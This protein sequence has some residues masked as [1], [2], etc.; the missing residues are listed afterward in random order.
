MEEF[1]YKHK[2][3]LKHYDDNN[4]EEVVKKN[5]IDIPVYYINL[6]RCVDRRK[7]IEKQ[8][9]DFDIKTLKRIRAVDGS[10][11]RTKKKGTVSDS[12]KNLF[13][14]VNKCEDKTFRKN[15]I[16]CTLSH[17]MA[18]KDIIDG[19]DKHVLVIE[20]DMHF[21]LSKGW[22][23]SLTE[24]LK[25]HENENI[26][27]LKINNHLCNV[28]KKE[29]EYDL[30]EEVSAKKPYNSKNETNYCWST[31]A[32]IYSL[33]SAKKLWDRCY[34]AKT[35][36]IIIEQI[37]NVKPVADAFIFE[38]VDKVVSVSPSLI[39]PYK[40]GGYDSNINDIDWQITNSNIP[41]IDI[42]LDTIKKTN[43][44]DRE[45]IKK[46]HII[47]FEFSEKSK[48]LW[49]KLERYRNSCSEVYKD[50]E[51]KVWDE[52]TCD[53]LV[54]DNF[55]EYYKVYKNYENP[56]ERVDASRY[57]IQYLEGGM[58]IDTDIFCFKSIEELIRD[59]TIAI[60]GD[61]GS[62]KKKVCN[63][64]LYSGEIKNQFWEFVVDCM[65]K[66]KD[67]SSV[68]ERTGP[69]F[70]S[71]CVKAW[72]ILIPNSEIYII[73]VKYTKMFNWNEKIDGCKVD[74]SNEDFNKCIVDKPDD[75]YMMS[76]WGAGWT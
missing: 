47:W 21:G 33:E 34:D 71:K 44:I 26:D 68:V 73:P 52:E 29:G 31:G 35:N 20:D 62:D 11:I 53:K 3:L 49:D 67:K 56:V 76:S 12:A 75:L 48:Q 32:M 50:W 45:P 54:K 18:V 70:L 30:L 41:L 39:V 42:Y 51:I 57:I 23:F 22:D 59:K 19:G 65:I 60:C 1:E 55:P 72:E 2:Y 10:K 8:G 66:A 38:R 6:D 14:W 37:Y 46:L 4:N 5:K 17:I 69:D 43:G 63:D 13:K 15:E 64:I 24:F 7:H 58:Y 16:A 61:Y 9:V 40:E 74:D 28:N 27:I 25:K 36:T